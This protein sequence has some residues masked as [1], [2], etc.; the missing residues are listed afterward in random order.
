VHPTITA[1]LPSRRRL[2]YLPP[3]APGVVHADAG[4]AAWIGALRRAAWVPTVSGT[5]ELP[6]NVSLEGAS[7]GG[8]AGTGGGGSGAGS[9]G[10]LETLSPSVS[11]SAVAALRS[12]PLAAALA[13]GTRPP[14]SPVERVE[15]LARAA[16]ALTAFKRA[17]PQPRTNGHDGGGSE[18]SAPAAPLAPSFSPL[19]AVAAVWRAVGEAAAAGALS[20]EER[21]RIRAAAEEHALLPAARHNS[22]HRSGRCVAVSVAAGTA[23]LNAL[24]AEAR[25]GGMSIGAG[26]EEEADADDDTTAAA[27]LGPAL[28]NVTWLL[29]FHDP[30]WAVRDHGAVLADL[31]GVPSAATSLHASTYISFLSKGAG[32]PAAAAAV[33]LTP[34]QNAALTLS[35]AACK[36]RGVA[37]AS[38]ATALCGGGPGHALHSPRWWRYAAPR[39]G[40]GYTHP[41]LNDAPH[42]AAHLTPAHGYAF[43]ASLN[44]EGNTAMAR[45]DASLRRWMGIGSLSQ[46]GFAVSVKRVASGVGHTTKKRGNKGRAAG[47]E[48]EE[49]GGEGL[50]LPDA[51]RRLSIVLAIV[52][53]SST[54]NDKTH[55]DGGGGGGGDSADVGGG[56]GKEDEEEGDR[57]RR[58][59][60]AARHPTT[61]DLV[62]YH[63]LM[64]H[65]SVP[66]FPSLPAGG[67]GGRGGG[68]FGGSASAAVREPPPPTACFAAWDA[69][70]G[71]LALAGDPEDY[72]A[73][74]QDELLTALRPPQAAAG[75]ERRLRKAFGLL[76]HVEDGRRFRKFLQRDFEEFLH[77]DAPPPPLPPPQQQQ[78]EQ[79]QAGTVQGVSGGD[80]GARAVDVDVDVDMDVPPPPP[81]QPMPP[82]PPSLLGE[83]GAAALPPLPPVGQRRLYKLHAADPPIA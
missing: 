29:N 42:V 71:Q 81:L 38:V 40:D 47:E 41:V 74:F 13:F 49:G 63:A 20:E 17:P 4:E 80:G 35:L 32:G 72:L 66:A 54:S 55:G 78:Q 62:K 2:V 44:H 25:R 56:K 61:P 46:G 58:R 18:D 10:H 59:G 26:G 75:G 9:G 27:A 83:A 52:H 6:A 30:A 34:V 19:S 43:L 14:P 1:A 8:G 33:H 24:T 51:T 22:R 48:G 28:A 45:L 69:A 64:R 31:L 70:A 11:A 12:S 16:A 5:L 21:R 39:G 68:G 60:G 36:R 82:P 67:R 57:R 65:V 7:T 53:P 76:T 79:Q 50:A 3:G 77:L 73:D 23:A 15:S 37:P